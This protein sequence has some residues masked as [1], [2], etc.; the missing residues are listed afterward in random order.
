M[1]SINVVHLLSVLRC[2]RCN[3]VKRK[4]PGLNPTQKQAFEI[5]TLGVGHGH[6]MILTS[7]QA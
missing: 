1:L 5:F 4:I 3:S 6:R 2:S 7:C